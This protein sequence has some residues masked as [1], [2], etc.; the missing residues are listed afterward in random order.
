MTPKVMKDAEMGSIKQLLF[1]F[2]AVVESSVFVA[3]RSVAE[4]KSNEKY[5]V[6]MG[7]W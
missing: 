4:L 7:F 3:Q 5:V 6:H 2:I 1:K